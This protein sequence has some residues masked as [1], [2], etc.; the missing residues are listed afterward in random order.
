LKKLERV[1]RDVTA[2][3]ETRKIKAPK[4]EAWST[5]TMVLDHLQRIFDKRNGAAL[6]SLMAAPVSVGGEWLL[7]WPALLAVLLK[8]RGYQ[9]AAEGVPLGPKCGQPLSKSERGG[10]LMNA[11]DSP[12]RHALSVA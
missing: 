11:D 4:A 10:R 2:P 6:T 8:V 5:W 7:C 1:T 3:L 9:R 12:E